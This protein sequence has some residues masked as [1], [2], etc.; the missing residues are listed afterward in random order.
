MPV[1]ERKILR[2]QIRREIRDE[3]QASYVF[4]DT[5]L[6]TYLSNTIREYSKRIPREVKASLALIAGQADYD[7]PEGLREVIGIT[8]G[9]TAYNVTDIFG[10]LMTLS[11]VPSVSAT[12]AFKH[13]GM[14]TIPTADT[15]TG[16]TSTYDSIDEP[17]IATRVK[18]QCWE[19]LA[20]DGAKYY[21]YQEGDIREN[22][23]K[24]QD[25]FR[26]EADKLFAEF[27]AGCDL[28]IEARQVL[29][30]VPTRTMAGVVTR[31]KPAKSATIYKD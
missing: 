11:P 2:D 26:K 13:R 6:N 24:T 14:H 7:A 19:T 25:Q 28:S 30:P 18:A 20:G 10:G 3:A 1:L 31:Q 17:L 22:Q 15:G 16:S 12:A 23:G 9:A 29:Q 5:E 4:T 27:E 21:D 8:V